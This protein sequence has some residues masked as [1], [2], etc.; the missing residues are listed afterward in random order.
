MAKLTTRQKAGIGFGIFGLITVVVATRAKAA[1]P[2]EY[3]CPYCLVCF[4]TYQELVDHVKTAHPGE[5]IPLPIE[6][7]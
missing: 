7:D 5:R 2:L 6:W 4:A 3:C 1:P